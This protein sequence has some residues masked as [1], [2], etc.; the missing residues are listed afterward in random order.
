MLIRFA[1]IEDCA[2]RARVQVD[3]YR[4]AYAGILPQ[5]NLGHLTYA[6]QEQDW[7]E[8][9]EVRL[10]EVPL[11]AMDE[12]VISYALGQPGKGDVQR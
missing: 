3:S 7:R 5:E 1:K 10:E 8:L 11:V 4:N 9:L 2:G 12:Q 6:E